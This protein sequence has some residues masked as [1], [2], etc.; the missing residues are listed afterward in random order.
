MSKGCPLLYQPG[1]RQARIETITPSPKDPKRVNDI[2]FGE[3]ITAKVTPESK[4]YGLGLVD[5]L[6]SQGAEG[7]VLGCT[8]IPFLIQ[9]ADT[10]TRSTTLR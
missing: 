1:V 5:E 4:A 8:E 10:A 9:Q 3:L 2:I 6:A 7:V